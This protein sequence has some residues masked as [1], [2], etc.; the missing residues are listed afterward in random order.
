MWIAK[1]KNTALEEETSLSTLSLV[2][3]D[4]HLVIQEIS[5]PV[6]PLQ[7]PGSG[8]LKNKQKINIF[9]NKR[10]YLK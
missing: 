3:L 6:I 1:G 10:L 9:Q 2:T 4:R 5:Q 7:I 8:S